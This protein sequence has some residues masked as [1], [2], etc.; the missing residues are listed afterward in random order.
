MARRHRPDFLGDRCHR[1][2]APTVPAQPAKASSTSA[3]TSRSL[4]PERASTWEGM[5]GLLHQVQ[6][7]RLA[8]NSCDDGFEQAQFRQRVA[9]P[10]QEQHG[11]TD[12]TEMF[13]PI[14]RRFSRRMQG[15]AE[16]GEPANAR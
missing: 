13:G 4:R 15:K 2:P 1:Y 12:I 16:E 7:R 6:R 3:I 14:D 8:P 11:D 5:V 10:L 9:R